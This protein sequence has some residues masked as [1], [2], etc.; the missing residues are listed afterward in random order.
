MTHDM[1]PRPVVI[2]STEPYWNATAEDRL[3][4]PKYDGVWEPYPRPG[5]RGEADWQ[6]TSRTGTVHTFSVSR[7]S[8]Y[9]DLEAPYVVALVDL[10]EGPRIYTNLVHVEPEDVSIGMK[11]ELTFL[12]LDDRKLPVFRPAS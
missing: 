3:D 2:P 11:V 10:D 7:F 4:L 12:D 6:T 5:A 9:Q 8:P 1:R